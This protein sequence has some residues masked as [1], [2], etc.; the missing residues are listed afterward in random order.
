MQACCDNVF[1]INLAPLLFLTV[2]SF[3]CTSLAVIEPSLS[4]D[5]SKDK[6]FVL[7]LPLF[8]L[9]NSFI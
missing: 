9:C 1:T 6:L 7:I 5:V 4:N 8:L 3:S 2:I